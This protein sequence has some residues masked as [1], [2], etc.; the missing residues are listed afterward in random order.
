MK[1]LIDLWQVA[2]NELGARCGV[3]TTL[4]LKKLQGRV[5]HEGLS[6]LTITLPSFASDFQKSLEAGKVGPDLFSSFKKRGCLPLFLG[7][8]MDRVFDRSAGLLLDEPDIDSIFAIRQLTLMFGKILLPCSDARVRGAMNK[9]ILCEQEVRE[10]DKK[11]SD[12]D[13]E[14][15]ARLS[16]LMWAEVFSVVDEAV[17]YGEITPHHG[18]GSTAD[19]LRGN[20]KFDQREW[21]ERLESVFPFLENALPNSRYHSLLDHVDFLEPGTE[22]PV[23][24]VPVPKTLKTPRIIAIEPT[25][26]QYMQQGIKD[27]I[28]DCI[29][30][31]ERYHLS[32]PF[33]RMIGFE[34]QI[35]NQDLA[36]EGSLSSGNLATLDL[37]EASDR[38]SN[39]LVRL[40]LRN[41]PHLFE[42]VDATRSRKADVPGHGV[43]R[44]AKFASMG[45][46]LCFPFEAMVFLTICLVG[47]ERESKSQLTKKRIHTFLGKVRVYGDDIIVPIEYTHSVVNTLEAFGFKV[48]KD[49]SFW[50]GKFRESCGKEYY[51]GHD[52]SICRVR[53]TFPARRTDAQEVISLVALRNQ[54][55][56]IGLWTTAGYLDGIL[57]RLLG[58]FPSI[59]PSSPLLGRH[60]LLEYEYSRMCDRLHSPLVKGYVVRS[61]PPASKVSGVGAL[62]KCLLKRSDEPFADSRHLERQGR[63]VAV[64]IKLGMERP[65]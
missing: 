15:F 34:D 50:N 3:S 59:H 13:R 30:N 28:Y 20:A 17:Y 60:T 52:V 46:A 25:A 2:S 58:R 49:K 41:H 26:M 6:F 33:S 18:P 19:R 24:V 51:D 56:F 36:L 54:F 11:L 53:R 5:E 39:Q 21:P 42:A 8:F 16:S 37:S 14:D 57:K 10:Y 22:R 40:M 29:E 38:V 55:Y 4:D 23:R 45:S 31:P 62:L 7:G 47:I 35:P 27:M 61:T 63:P 12:E 44:L 9:F 65:F 64:N 48:N 43:I 1:S 32:F